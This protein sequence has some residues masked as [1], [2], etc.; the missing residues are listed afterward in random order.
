MSGIATAVET[1]VLVRL[2]D[3]RTIRRSPLIWRT[4]DLFRSQSVGTRGLRM[5][6]K[7]NGIDGSSPV[8]DMA[9]TGRRL[10]K[11]SA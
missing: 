5:P 8:R 1:V 6:R 2:Q 11:T 4:V 9:S 3:V 7:Q 10:T